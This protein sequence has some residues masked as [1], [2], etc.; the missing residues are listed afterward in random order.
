MKNLKTACNIFLCICLLSLLNQ[1][2]AQSNKNGLEE[3]SHFGTNP[4]NLKLFVHPP[5]S[6]DSLPKAL[7]LVLHGCSQSAA[8]IAELSGW[9]K[10]ADSNNF[11]VFYPQQKI[12]NNPN[13][14]F[15]WFN[16]KDVNK[17]QGECESIFEMI[18]YAQA[19]YVIDSSRIFITGMSAGAAMSLAMLATHPETFQAGAIFAGGAYKIAQNAFEAGIA[20]TG[21]KSE[22]HEVLKARIKGQNPDYKGQY[23]RLIL[24]QGLS[25]PVV[26]PRNAQLI[27]DQWTGIHACDTL[28]D[29][30]EAAYSGI[31]DITRKEYAD[32]NGR[33]MLIYFEVKN[34]GHRLMVKP[35]DGKEEGG[36]TSLFGIDKGYHSTWHTARDFGILRE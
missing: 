34:L 32:S 11:I 21:G 7:V 20:M 23:P 2:A 4:G 18:A 35:G 19:H 27:I 25:D 12:L 33:V 30:T 17:G 36:Q 24:Y 29:K 9:N 13:L 22:E 1:L 16:K 14:C 10:L 31:A 6:T 8:D 5:T 15:N 3:I 26:H 28:P